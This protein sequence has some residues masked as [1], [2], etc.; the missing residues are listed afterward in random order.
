MGHF[1]SQNRFFN[2]MLFVET[3][4]WVC[5]VLDWL[6][7]WLSADLV[8]VLLWILREK[9]LFSYG[10]CQANGSVD[11][12]SFLYFLNVVREI[13]NEI[14][15]NIGNDC[16]R[17]SK[18]MIIENCLINIV[19]VWVIGSKRSIISSDL[20]F[21]IL[22]LR[23]IGVNMIVELVFSNIRFSFHLFFN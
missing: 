6:L 11:Q 12:F 3:T 14:V 10:G 4:D 19:D 22:K 8:K 15:E 23:V 20:P 9:E 1:I 18:L 13:V 2:K 17:V 21:K 7:L 5:V 16:F